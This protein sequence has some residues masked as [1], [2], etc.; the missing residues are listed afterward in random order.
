MGVDVREFLLFVIAL[1]P[2]G[3]FLPTSPTDLIKVFEAITRNGL[4]DYF[5]YSPLVQIVKKFGA[6]NPKMEAWIKS[7]KKDLKVYAIVAS[8]EDYIESD[9]DTCADQSRED[10]AKYDPRY[11]CPVQWKTKFVDHSLQHLT[12]VWE[13]FSDQY[14]VPDSPPTALLDRVRKGCVSVTWLVP[15]YLIPQ[16]VERVKM[17]T[18]FFQMFRILKV[19]VKGETVYE[20]NTD[21]SS[22]YD[23][24][25]K[26][27]LTPVF[28]LSCNVLENTCV[29]SLKQ[30]PPT[31]Q[32]CKLADHTL[33]GTKRQST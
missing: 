17:D 1:F 16:L 26:S 25:R 6:G 21:V 7:Y 20:E 28:G 31:F 30:I 13:V 33:D 4:W 22:K 27:N 15:S 8:I 9:L 23:H 19:T 2:P 12:N 3:D 5:H 24:S 29:P 18:K 32:E 14:L 10:S 11:S